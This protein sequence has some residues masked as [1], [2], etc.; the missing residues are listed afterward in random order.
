V[1]LPRSY[2]EVVAAIGVIEE[3]TQ[4]DFKRAFGKS[5]DIAKDITTMTLEGGVIV[6]GVAEDNSYVARRLTPVPLRGARERVQQIAD[7]AIRPTPAIEIEL[8]YEKPG[9][10]DG[11]VVVT[12]PAS[13]LVPHMVEGRYP[14]RSGTVTR[15]LSEFEVERLYKQREVLAGEAA[16]REFMGGFIPPNGKGDGFGVAV[17]IGVM[18]LFVQ[19]VTMNRHPFG[20]ALRRPLRKAVMDAASALGDY[21]S[22][23]QWPAALELLQEWRPLDVT[24]WEAGSWSESASELSKSNYVAAVYG[25][26]SGFSFHVTTMVVFPRAN[27]R[28]PCA[29]ESFWAR[30]AMACLSI[31]GQFLRD[32]PGTS[33]AF[34]DLSLMGLERCAS[35][36]ACSAG[37]YDASPKIQVA[38]YVESG[39]YSASE[40]ATDPRRATV[41]L[42]DKLFA[43]F[44]PDAADPVGRLARAE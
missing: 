24:G 12:V 14:T 31:A 2:A 7:S 22:P 44:L 34:A 3:S 16:G 21:I 35:T 15:N 25:H 19:P 1:W 37:A 26:G 43:S 33:F 4:L 18:R 41:E 13:P 20:A 30:E 8:L 32:V 40:L 6:Y 39:R 28:Y 42:F 36:D 10:A 11:F 29:H 5:E 38:R 23:M 17:E 27:Y 9:D